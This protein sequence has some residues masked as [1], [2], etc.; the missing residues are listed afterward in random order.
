LT[1]AGFTDIG[2]TRTHQ[3]AD[4]MHSAI[5]TARKPTADTCFGVHGLGT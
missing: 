3:I 1:A 2:I 5:I 4:G